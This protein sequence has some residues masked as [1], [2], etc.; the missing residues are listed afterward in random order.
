MGTIVLIGVW[1]CE[2]KQSAVVRTIQLKWPN[3]QSELSNM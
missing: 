2:A 1:K 3:W